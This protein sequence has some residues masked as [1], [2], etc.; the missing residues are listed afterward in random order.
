MLRFVIQL[1]LQGCQGISNEFI[2][3]IECG[4]FPAL[5]LFDLG[6]VNIFSA[7]AAESLSKGR[8]DLEI[9][10]A[11]DERGPNRVITLIDI[12]CF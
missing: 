10:G 8:P 6:W 12:F 9:V 11:I 7:P 2:K 1:C 4:S 5:T 3:A